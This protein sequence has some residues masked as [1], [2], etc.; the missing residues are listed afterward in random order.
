MGTSEKRKFVRI[1]DFLPVKYKRV[2]SKD[3]ELAQFTAT[4]SRTVSVN[5]SMP[6]ISS[7]AFDP[8]MFPDPGM[9]Y[10]AEMINV[11]N[12]KL[13]TLYQ[14]VTDIQRTQ[15]EFGSSFIINLSAIG[16]Q[17]PLKER[18]EEDS[19]I[20]LSFVLNE[21]PPKRVDTVAKVIRIE[22][23]D[24]ESD[25]PYRAAVEFEGLDENTTEHIVKYVFAVM[26]RGLRGDKDN[27]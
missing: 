25:L 16:M 4:K 11:I 1:T 21:T 6:A 8:G 14:Q 3:I 9:L 19:Y 2:D 17:F 22:T 27:K 23:I 7:D 24:L 18:L 10:I 15:E 26:R 5:G 12:N 13:D 20:L